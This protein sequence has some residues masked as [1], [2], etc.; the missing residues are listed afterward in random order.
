MRVVLINTGTELLLGDVRDAHLSFIAREILSLGL[1]INEQRTVPD[2]DAIRSALDDL[3][4]KAE[5]IVI[6]GGLGP[7]TDDITREMVA[8]VTGLELEHDP[9][10]MSAITERLTS[11]GIKFTDRIARQAQVPRGARVLPNDNGTAPGFYLP[12]TVTSGKELPHIFVLPGPTRELQPIFRERVIPI[13]REIAPASALTRR[14]YRITGL[15]ESLV[16]KRIGKNMH[17]ISGIELGYCARPGEVDVRIVG[18]PGPIG[19][20]DEI[21]RRDLESFI[22]STTDESLEE[23]LI[24]TL[25]THDASL[26]VAESCTGGSLA[27]RLTN[28]AGASRIFVAGYITYANEAKMKMLG[29]EHRLLEQHG[30]VSDPVARAMAQ[31]V[32]TRSGTTYGLSTTGIAGPDGGS[33]EKPV[34]TVYVGLATPG[35]VEARQ[36]F[37]LTDRL[38][39]KDMVAQTAFDLLRRELLQA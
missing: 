23:V 33:E 13:L 5:I 7:T 25:Q 6:T 9:A 17:A 24:R 31:G 36:F 14:L 34:G 30:A 1:R 22:F 37:F 18:Q 38:T 8:D 19:Q 10:V 35:K 11:R 32:R 4:S 15:G 3:L 20:A 29:V 26:A 16:E 12:R 39:F 2:G 21:I 27:N 28:I